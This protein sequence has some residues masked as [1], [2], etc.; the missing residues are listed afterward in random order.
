MAQTNE[1]SL[2]QNETM[3]QSALN[4]REYSSPQLVTLDHPEITGKL[5]SPYNDDFILTGS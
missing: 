2:L 5:G 1:A 4:R 3:N